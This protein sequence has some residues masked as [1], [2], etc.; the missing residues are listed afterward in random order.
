MVR[1]RVRSV[2]E[3]QGLVSGVPIILEYDL[4]TLTGLSHFLRVWK[5]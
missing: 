2:D 1:V 3:S 4:T 5:T